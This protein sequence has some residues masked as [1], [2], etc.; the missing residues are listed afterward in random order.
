MLAP[1]R[2]VARDEALL[3]SP[4][5]GIAG[6]HD[7]RAGPDRHPVAGHQG[8]RRPGGPGNEDAYHSH[9]GGGEPQQHGSALSNHWT[10]LALRSPTP[11]DADGV[12][13]ILRSGVARQD[14]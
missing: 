5:V 13:H 10:L 11:T 2:G 7:R 12:I 14:S 9:R 1:V 4:G 6:L 8:P 3:G